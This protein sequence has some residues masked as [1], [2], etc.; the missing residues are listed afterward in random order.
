MA[1][2]LRVLG[3][4][5]HNLR[6]VDVTFGPGVTAVVGVSGSGKS[7]LAFDVVYTE[8]RRRFLESLGLGRSGARVPAAHVRS[9]EG[10][11]P[12][13][14]IAQNVVN[15]NPA[16]TVATSVGLHPFL[17]ILYARFADVTCPNCQVPVRAVSREERLAIAL[18]MLAAAGRLAVEVAVVRGLRRS[19]ARL[20]SGL[21]GQF[22]AVTIDG[23][24]WAASNTSR[25]PR[26]DP[27]APHDVVV[28]VATLHPGASAAEVRA[29]L[30][31][32]DALGS[33]EVRLGGTPVLRAPICP[34][35]S[36][37]VRPLEPSAFRD[38][39]VDTSSH[40]I[41]GLTLTE[42]LAHSVSEV[43]EFVDQLPVGLRAARIQNELLRRLRPLVTLG[44]GH[45]SLDRSM[46]TLSRGEA[47][48]TRL[49][50]VLGGRLEDLLHVLDE[51]TIGLHHTDLKRLLDAIA[52][53]PGPVLMVE[54]DRTAIA[55]A[56]D[57]V[58][59]GPA[60]G[61]GGGEFVFQG[62]PAALWRADT[63]S[64]RSFSAPT[65]ARRAERPIGEHRIRITGASM[66]NLCGVDCEIPLGALT[67]IT[68]PS[69]AG[70][71]TLARDVLLESIR[72]N[73]PIGCSTFDAP[74]VRAVAVEQKPLGNNPRSNPATY[75]KVFDRI[76]DV[77]ANETGRTASEFT[78]N[79]TE[80]ACPECEGMGAVA[81]SMS[82]LAPVW[83][84]CEVCESR[85][86]RPEV[87]EATWAGRSIADVLALSVDEAHAL[88]AEHPSVTRILETLQEVGLGY[89]TLGQPSPSLSGGEA[90]RVRLARQVTKA[91]SGDLVLL[92]E[93]TTG[94]HP[95][96]LGR[97]LDV[98]DK[99]TANG[100]TVVVVEHQAD[101][102]AAADWR[103]D[104]GPGGGPN[105][106]RLEHCGPPV[107]EK[108]PRVT[109]RA[110][111]RAGRRSSDAIRVRGARAHNLQ[112]VDVQFAKDRFTVVTGVSG[113]GKS[114]LVRDVVAAEANRRLLECL[115]VYER[116]SVREGPE[117]PVDSLTGLGPTMSIDASGTIFGSSGAGN[118]VWDAARTTVG[119]SSDL[120][121][122]ISV[123]LA[124][125]GVRTCLACGR[126]NVRRISPA[127]EAAWKCDDCDT[128][129]VPIEPRHLIGSPVAICPQCLGLGVTRQFHFDRWV[130]QPDAPICAGCFRGSGRGPSTM[131]SASMALLG[132]FC[133]EGTGGHASLRAFAKRQGFDLA[134]TPWSELTEEA[135]QAFMF[136]DP[137]PTNEFSLVS[138]IGMNHWA[139]HDLGGADTKASPCAECGGRRLRAPYLAI[140]LQGR[141]RN[142]LFSAS[143]AELAGVLASMDEPEDEHAAHARTV[144]LHR[145]RFLNSV[146]LG[147]LDLNRATWTL[148]AGEAQ[149]IKLASVLGSGL[150][151]MT[152][153]LDE[154]S[155]GLHPSEVDA[156]ARTLS[157]LRDVGNTVIAVEHDPTLI[158]AAD[159]IIEIGPG[160]GR[161]GGRLIDLD[162]PESVTRAVLDGRISIPRRDRRREPTGWMHVTG[163]RE[164]NLRG[165]DVRIPLGVQVGVCG[166]SGS[167]KSSLVVDTIALGLA[168]PKTNIPHSG[169]IRVE[170]GVHDAI[171]GAPDRTIVADQARAE[172]TSPGMFLGLINAV[173]KSFAASEVAREH[174]ITIKDL[175]YGCDACGGKGTWQEDM[176]FLPSVTQTCDACSGTGYRRE[177]ATLA[178]RGRTLADIEALT[179]AELVEEWGDIDAVRRVGG[180]AVALGLGY[181][182]VRQPSWSLSGGEA[183]RLKL[184]KELARPAKAGAL[185]VLDEPTV[186]LQATD[187]AVLAH[188]LATI[189][190]A[191]N[192]VLVVEHD[193]ILLATCDWLIELGPG[194]G[195]D[196][197]EIVFEGPPEQL[198]NADTATA[199][200][201]LEAIT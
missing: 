33:P 109:P 124:R 48:R 18:D 35:C 178:E 89:V 113:S 187:V 192:T 105:G 199:P 179:I 43:L 70:K 72:D 107:A 190:D 30:E 150:V 84:P 195:P 62:P 104:L 47:Q 2:K 99:L 135:R 20:L 51:P 91:K 166:V 173:R 121:R 73:A 29:I 101:V 129:A 58:E 71:T 112:G 157:E 92:D 182:I 23:S 19:H 38:A 16:S 132:Y 25:V 61:R 140:R 154:P 162:S 156:L 114:S 134:T 88:F 12:A 86:Y 102:I 119:R 142:D 144:A 149:R 100:C 147:Y 50:V 171:S 161:A 87:L 191:G 170:P 80:G 10:L 126:D 188:A 177:V 55:M 24:P 136:G 116:Q 148:S 155:R 34:N 54:H 163:A 201:L 97:L 32:A 172:I 66:R 200:Y 15:V 9:I 189:V 41:A 106:G 26:L 133:K 145:L 53:L 183:Q 6:D 27:T 198:A 141:D 181:L 65:H 49:A 74:A 164:N 17:R 138:W 153:L 56:D 143:F 52:S 79:R 69:G 76:R 3:A 5:E 158:R 96:D 128:R 103:I 168:R 8:A 7:S 22:D 67:V 115:S 151:G 185:H 118:S 125:A 197:G 180:A 63:A 194:A 165:L 98:L 64:G 93:P 77:F 40:R 127:V 21:R 169:I 175:T 45:L 46:P 176:S 174:G 159:D 11:G 137:S 167:G 152:V 4:A 94:L 28:R 131:A 57:V 81:I 123:V 14:A 122:L 75:T 110:K 37:W 117:A 186:G 146:G 42:L 90:Q 120:D 68:G 193:P 1:G 44:L 139:Q 59:I 13:V 36:D 160:P 78:F 196:G 60:G 184:A 82:Y 130:V 108:R 83:I 85:R 39:A 31:R 111:P 95:A